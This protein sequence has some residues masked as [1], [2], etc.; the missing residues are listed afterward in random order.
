MCRQAHYEIESTTTVQAKHMLKY[1]RISVEAR[2]MAPGNIKL[3]VDAHQKN[4]MGK[5]DTI[6]VME[7]R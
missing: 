4:A 6:S 1:Y 5:L 3:G 2:Q 7:F